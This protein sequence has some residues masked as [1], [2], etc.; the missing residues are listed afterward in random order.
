MELIKEVAEL[1]ETVGNKIASANKKIRANGGN[2]DETDV[3]LIDKLSH[4]L[5]SLAAV[6]KM[7]EE[8]EEGDEG[9]SGRY[10]PFNPG[11]GYSREGRG[12]SGEGSGYSRE[13]RGYSGYSREGRGYSRNGGYSRT[14]DMT[15]QLRQLMDD[16]PDDMT[17]QEIKRL[18]ERMERK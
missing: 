8:E 7:L 10:M 17:R 9:Y 14:G 12:Y 4:S 3:N 13:G 6:C 2:I 11:Y 18:I 5:K 16:A 15:E 1:K